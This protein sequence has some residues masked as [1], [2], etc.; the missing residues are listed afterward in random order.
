MSYHHPHAGNVGQCRKLRLW[1]Q[2]VGIC[3]L[4]LNQGISLSSPRGWQ[5]Q[6]SPEPKECFALW[7]IS[8]KCQPHWAWPTLPCGQCWVCKWLSFFPPAPLAW[9]SGQPA[10]DCIYSWKAAHLAF[11]IDLLGVTLFPPQQNQQELDA[12]FSGHA[13]LR[14]TGFAGSSEHWTG[15]PCHS[16]V[17]PVGLSPG[18]QRPWPENVV[19][20]SPGSEALGWKSLGAQ[21]LIHV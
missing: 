20:P 6:S 21:T 2:D 11:Y 5:T 8:R 18:P 15:N 3:G 17:Q 12:L 4:H 9:L 13:K 10:A 16:Q 1:I 7:H 19:S 14:A